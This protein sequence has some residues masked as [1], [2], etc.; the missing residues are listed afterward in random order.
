MFDRKTGAE[1]SVLQELCHFVILTIRCLY[2][3][4]TGQSSLYIPRDKM[5]SMQSSEVCFIGFEGN[6][7]ML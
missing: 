5:V 6:S 7:K 3:D 1:G 4:K 2:Y